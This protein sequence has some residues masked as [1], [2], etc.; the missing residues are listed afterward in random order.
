MTIEHLLAIFLKFYA[1]GPPRGDR[2]GW[3]RKI[4]NRRGELASHEACG[5]RYDGRLAIKM[6]SPPKVGEMQHR[7][8]AARA[9]LRW[10]Q[11]DLAGAS[12]VSLPTIN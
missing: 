12:S 11:R 1:T 10:E 4:L 7:I 6:E 5:R 9:L 8:C 3:H 2:Q